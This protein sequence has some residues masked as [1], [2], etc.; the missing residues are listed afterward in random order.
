M[1]HLSSTL[2]VQQFKRWFSHSN[3][4]NF[5]VAQF[6]GGEFHIFIHRSV[7]VHLSAASFRFVVHHHRLCKW[8]FMQ[9]HNSICII[10]HFRYRFVPWLD[11]LQI[12]IRFHFC[13]ISDANQKFQWIFNTCSSLPV[14]KK[15]PFVADFNPNSICMAFHLRFSWN[16]HNSIV[17]GKIV[18]SFNSWISCFL[19]IPTHKKKGLRGA[20]SFALAIRNTVSIARQ[21]MLTTTSLIVIFT[22]ITQGGAANFLLKFFQIPWVLWEYAE[23]RQTVCKW[24]YL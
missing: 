9:F 11:V 18:C 8:K 15:N 21:S 19:I 23:C 10:E 12:F 4:T 13:W 20:M 6:F 24:Q 2:H 22:V 7:D 5:W 3:E 17:A 16:F 14:K 1:W